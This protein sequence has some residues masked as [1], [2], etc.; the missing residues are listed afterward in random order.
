MNQKVLRHKETK[1]VLK[2]KYRK[3]NRTVKVLKEK[4]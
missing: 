1:R 4:A 3:T 2:Y